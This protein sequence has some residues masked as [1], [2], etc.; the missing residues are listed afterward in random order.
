MLQTELIN[1]A[2]GVYVIEKLQQR[3]AYNTAS[4]RGYSDISY[5]LQSHLMNLKKALFLI[6]LLAI[7]PAIFA[8]TKKL[9]PAGT[10]LRRPKLV[11]G[12]VVDQ[13]RWDYLYR[14]YDRYTSGGFRRMLNQ[15]FSCENTNIDYIP[16]ITAIG[17]SSIYTGSVPAIHGIAGNDFIIKATG[18]PTYCTEDTSVT[19]VGGV[20]EGKMSPRNLL[21]ST[22]T[23]ELKLATNFRSKVF[24]IALKDRGAILPAGH[25]PNAAFWYD[26][27][28]GNWIT[29][30]FYMKEL[31]EW[32][33]KFNDQKL[34]EKYMKQD[35]NTL[36]PISTYVQSSP[37]NNPYETKYAGATTPTFPIKTSE[38]KGYAAIRSTPYGNTLT[39]DMARA[40]IDNEGMGRDQTT[41]FLAVSLSSIDHL[42]HQLGPNSVEMEDAF[43]RLDR[44]L[45]SFLTYLD[46]KI[47]K[48]QYTVFLTADHGGAHNPNLLSDKNIPAGVWPSATILA[49]LNAALEA[50]YSVKNIVTSFM[51]YQVQL[52]HKNME[53]AKLNQDAVRA[54]CVE[55]LK[56]QDGVAF[57]VDMVDV[58][59]VNIP[60]ELRQRIVK[61]Y[62]AER[63]GE[64]QIVLK[65][66]WYQG[67]K[68]G[69]SHGT[70]N[71]Y[72]THI[73]LVWMGWGIQPGKTYAP[74]SMTDIAPTVAAL[75]HIQAPNGS[76]GKPITEML[77]W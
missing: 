34:V 54:D 6:I 37:D 63:S 9:E 30:T 52:S 15:G 23:D 53:A 3:R 4:R 50:K 49:N 68:T 7:S 43:L 24:G 59:S 74:I 25:T 2:G 66:G 73:P 35:W 38:M 41:D 31:P 11:V 77:Y 58:N 1:S 46:E 75:L 44:D 65:P 48:G 10:A 13:M 8:Q 29:S 69:T 47:G 26:G 19:G 70:W 60:E 57:I 40:L 12:L 33:K 17:H 64:I 18:K 20:S 55:F 5:L 51:N 22:I 42:G 71:P 72:D 76:I 21:A 16:T 61:G 32:L 36:Y 28:N 27:G 14:Y 56:K 39:F 62:N 67:P 45:A